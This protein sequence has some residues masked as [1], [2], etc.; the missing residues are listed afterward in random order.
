MVVRMDVADPDAPQAHDDVIS[1]CA[2]AAPQL[3]VGP[4]PAVQQHAALQGT[5]GIRMRPV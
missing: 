1:A 2:V 3:P 5:S 4:L